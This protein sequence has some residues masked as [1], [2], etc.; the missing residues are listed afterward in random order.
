MLGRNLKKIILIFI[1][2]IFLISIGVYFYF[3]DKEYVFSFSES[4]IR[5]KLATKLP[6]NKKYLLF[7]EVRLDNPRVSLTNGSNRVAAGLDVI[8]NIWIDKNP[9]P[10]GGSI[11]ATG[12]IKYVKDSGEFFLT[13]P[14]IEHLS[15]QGIPD[16]YTKKVNL[17][18]TKALS[19]YYDSHPIYVLKP[20]DVKKAAARLVLKNVI[21]KNQNLV[22]V[23]GI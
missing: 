11:D 7:F 21:I 5:E 18:L 2:T 6:L 8:L 17:V 15:M 1:A 23:L 22:V 9:K 3:S 19:E 10:L 20:I 4:Q 14:V 13:E 16:K 12:G